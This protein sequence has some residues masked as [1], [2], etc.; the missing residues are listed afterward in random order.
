MARAASGLS[1][2]DRFYAAERYEE[3]FD[4]IGE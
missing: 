2:P 4:S 3:I 1:Y